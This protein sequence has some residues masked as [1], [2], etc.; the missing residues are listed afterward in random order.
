MRAAP[1]FDQLLVI[2]IALVTAM[3]PFRSQS[4]SP[5]AFHI[6]LDVAVSSLNRT[7]VYLP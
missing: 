3:E 4:S 2:V 7:F 6:L 5:P 1:G